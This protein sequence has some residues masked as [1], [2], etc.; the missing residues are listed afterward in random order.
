MFTRDDAIEKLNARAFE[1][2]FIYYAEETGEAYKFSSWELDELVELMNDE[3]E[4][5]SG[6]AYSHW[7][8]A[9]YGELVEEDELEEG[10]RWLEEDWS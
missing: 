1:D 3:D 7:C 5:I 6:D 8:A 10:A 4:T 2:G 9:G